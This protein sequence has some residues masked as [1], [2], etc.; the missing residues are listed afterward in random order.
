MYVKE[1]PAQINR[2]RQVVLTGKNKDNRAGKS[3]RLFH[4]FF[5]EPNTPA[6]IFAIQGLP[7]CPVL[8]LSIRILVFFPLYSRLPTIA[9][10]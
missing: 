2:F 6:Y 1:E 9:M 3:Y 7:I 10:F 8:A 5:R 4:T